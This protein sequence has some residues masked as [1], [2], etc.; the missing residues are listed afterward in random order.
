MAV[1]FL[2]TRVS[3]PNEDGMLKLKL[4]IEY[5]RATMFI[6]LVLGWDKT[7]NP[8]WSIDASYAVHMEMKNHNRYRVTMG[9]GVL[10][11]GSFK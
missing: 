8:V 6:P 7:E 11:S 9:E 5:I 4:V 1:S 10:I 2:C 3:S